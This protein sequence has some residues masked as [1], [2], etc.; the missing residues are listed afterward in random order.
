MDFWKKEFKKKAALFGAAVITAAF[1]SGFAPA[2]DF[3]SGQS[4]MLRSAT[5]Y[6]DDWVVNFWNSE[7]VHMDQ[8]LAQIAADGFNNIILC[9]PWRE[10]QPGLAPCS[11]EDYAWEKL[12][13]VMEAAARQN[14]SVMLRVGYTWDYG[15]DEDVLD[16]YTRLFYDQTV[17][18]SWIKYVEKLYKE[19]SAH[20]NFCGGFLTWEDFW[21]FTDQAIAWG[22]SSQGRKMAERTDYLDYLKEHYELEEVRRLYDGEIEEWDQVYFPEKELPAMRLLYEFYDDFLNRILAESQ[23]VFPDLSMEVR[24]DADPVY[25]LDET[26]YGF[27][28]TATFGCGSSPYTSLMYSASMGEGGS[29]EVTASR[30]LNQMA[31]VLKQLRGSNG[32]KPVYIDQLLFTDNTPGFE[33]NARLAADEKAEFLRDSAWVLR[34]HAMGYGIWTYRDYCNNKLFNAQFALGLEGWEGPRAKIEER[35]G[36]YGAVLSSGASLSQN[37]SSRQGGIA[38]EGV[39]VRFQ[40]ESSGTSDVTVRIGNVSKAVTISDARQVDL[41]FGNVVLDEFYIQS[42]GAD[43]R[44]DDL[45]VYTWITEGE[46]Y[47]FEGQP[48]SCLEGLRQ[49][50]GA[51]GE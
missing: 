38:G 36:N 21:N 7:S 6:S 13:R 14:L 30:A 43:L 47:D 39:K 11:Y 45:K 40:A 44:I 26:L 34:E 18:N 48:D 33:G 29:G 3:A 31:G 25:S 22:N 2:K 15:A 50:N 1:T 41:D 24:L 23:E 9:V 42:R 17:W 32:G 49:L 19:A 4:G 8:E 5:Y 27:T 12:D 46:I 51:L 28:H 35:D 37:I 10:F 20:E 16:R